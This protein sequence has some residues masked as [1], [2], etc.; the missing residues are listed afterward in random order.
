MSRKTFVN[1]PNGC[2]AEMGKYFN[3]KADATAE[4][5]MLG[6]CCRKKTFTLIELLVVV[7]IIAILAGMLLPALNAARNKARGISCSSNLKQFGHTEAMYE[8]DYTRKIPTLMQWQNS[9]GTADT[10]RR[11]WAGNPYYRSYFRL[12]DIAFGFKYPRNMLCP[13]APYTA[14][15]EGNLADLYYSYG[16]IVR[17]SEPDSTDKWI[18]EGFFP[19]IKNP[20]GKVLIA[21]NSGWFVSRNHITFTDW[22]AKWSYYESKDVSKLGVTTYYNWLRYPHQ[23]QSNALF[24][25]G[26]VQPAG[27][28]Q[29]NSLWISDDD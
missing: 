23:A 21:D 3:F 26:H 15:Y 10:N 22:L 2:D 25:D 14:I 6:S 29:D 12:P 18:L 1:D 8:N 24:F 19:N 20:S 9:S 5:A 11:V 17:P 13:M 7:A 28:I 27:R 4:K 16:R